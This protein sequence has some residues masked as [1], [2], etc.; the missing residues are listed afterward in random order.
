MYEAITA[1]VDNTKVVQEIRHLA[2]SN[3]LY[4]HIL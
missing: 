3:G 2:K 4:K 1:M